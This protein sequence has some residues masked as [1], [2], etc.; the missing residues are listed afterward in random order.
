[1]YHGVGVYILCNGICPRTNV[2]PVQ[3]PTL[4]GRVRLG[5][6]IYCSPRTHGRKGGTADY[7]CLSGRST[8]ETRKASFT[9][10]F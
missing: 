9:A 8:P 5:E 6:R 2:I 10:H 7:T 4:D 1:M 3:I